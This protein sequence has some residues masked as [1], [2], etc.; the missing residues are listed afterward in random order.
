MDYTAEIGRFKEY[1]ENH[2]SSGTVGVYI[3]ALQKWFSSLDG[4]MLDKDS[5]QEYIDLLTKTKSASTTNLQAHAIMRYFKWKGSPI[6]LDCPTIR[7]PEPEYLTMDQL[8]KVLQETNTVLEKTLITVLFDTAVRISELLNLELR[9]IDWANGFVSVV[10]KGGRKEQVNISDK[11]LD[12]LRNWL[13]VRQ[14]ESKRVFMNLTYY[15]AWSMIRAVGK[16]VKIKLHPHMMRHSRAAQMRMAGASLEDIRD[17][18]GHKNIGTTSS[19]Y[20]NLKAVDLKGRIP[21]W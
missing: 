19:I 16:R 18:L 6:S 17:H 5:A 20:S 21:Q 15:D 12:A 1:L 9:D 4:G 3:L 13:D 7:S 11:G 10:R 8:D 2:V 14:F